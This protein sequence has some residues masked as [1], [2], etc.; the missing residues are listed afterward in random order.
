MGQGSKGFYNCN[1][2]NE[3]EER[4]INIYICNVR[5]R[6][7]IYTQKYRY[8]SKCTTQEESHRIV[9]RVL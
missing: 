5:V 3:G 4:D 6:T 8:T 2:T 1:D 9:V 7:H